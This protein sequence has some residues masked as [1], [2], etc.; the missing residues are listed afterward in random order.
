MSEQELESL[1]KAFTRLAEKHRGSEA[2]PHKKNA[3]A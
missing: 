1:K 3:P 2:K